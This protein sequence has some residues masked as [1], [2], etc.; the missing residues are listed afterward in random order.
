MNKFL[1]YGFRALVV[2]SVYLGIN[3]VS[4]WMSAKSA[5]TKA[6]AALCKHAHKGLGIRETM[7]LVVEEPGYNKSDHNFDKR[8]TKAH[9]Y[10]LT[11][12]LQK[13]GKYIDP[14]PLIT[15]LENN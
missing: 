9:V 13:C 11:D 7:K 8:F 6:A 12:G 14:Q 1:E 5:G 2:G 15:A 3:Y 4:P 10:A